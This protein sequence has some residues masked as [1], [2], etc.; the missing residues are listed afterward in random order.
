MAK[1]GESP[2]RDLEMWIAMNERLI[3]WMHFSGQRWKDPKKLTRN[4]PRVVCQR[5]H[6][7]VAMMQH[8]VLE[9]KTRHID[10]AG[11]LGVSK[12]LIMRAAKDWNVEFGIYGA[13]QKKVSAHAD[14]LGA[15]GTYVEAGKRGHETRR[16]RIAER[17]AAGQNQPPLRRFL[18]RT[19]S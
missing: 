11:L 4:T 12:S 6:V 16:R 7:F 18:T 1:V 19:N 9:D 13:N 15:E 5:W 8:W 17:L 10:L 14:H 2:H 3:R